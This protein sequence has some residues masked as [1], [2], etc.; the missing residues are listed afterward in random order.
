MYG[1]RVGFQQV[2][3]HLDD[4]RSVHHADAAVVHQ[5][6]ILTMMLVAPV[7]R[8]VE[9]DTRDTR[10]DHPSV[11]EHVLA[12]QL[13]R[14]LRLRGVFVHLHGGQRQIDEHGRRGF[15]ADCREIQV[16]DHVLHQVALAALAQK[17]QLVVEELPGVL[18]HGSAHRQTEEGEYTFDDPERHVRRDHLDVKLRELLLEEL[19]TSSR[20]PRH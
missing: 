17:V 13:R 2:D 16:T 20:P 14:R 8:G 4:A 9:A 1:A 6:Q 11:E 19:L 15:E 3:A 10:R 5:P 12:L 18:L 7:E